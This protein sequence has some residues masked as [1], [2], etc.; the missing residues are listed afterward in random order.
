MSRRKSRIPVFIKNNNNNNK[1][2]EKQKRIVCMT[3]KNQDNSFDF[4]FQIGNDQQ[5]KRLLAN[6]G[7]ILV[8]HYYYFYYYYFL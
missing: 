5:S 8:F 6:L 1:N 3:K 7:R 2:N 4:I